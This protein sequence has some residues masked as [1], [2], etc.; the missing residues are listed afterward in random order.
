MDIFAQGLCFYKLFGVFV[1]GAFWGDVIETLFCRLK[2]GTWINR[3]SFLYGQFSVVWGFAFVLATLLFYNIADYPVSVIYIAG[4]LIGG[5]YEYGCSLITEK[6]LGTTFW[7]YSSMRFQIQG[8]VNLLYCQFWGLATVMW[9]KDVFPILESMIEKIPVK[10]GETLSNLLLILLLI[11][12]AIS[13]IA[14]K[15][16]AQRRQGKVANTRFWKRMDEVYPDKRMEKRYPVMKVCQ[17]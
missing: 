4:V 5:I 17:S 2:G 13:A 14:I 12:A 7:D 8:R 15:R 10:A 9:T 11:D 1:T 6:V 16:Y 3:S